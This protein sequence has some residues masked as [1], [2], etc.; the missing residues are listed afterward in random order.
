MKT[1]IVTLLILILLSSCSVV[2]KNGYY[3]SRTYKPRKALSIS[4]KKRPKNQTSHSPADLLPSDSEDDICA[5][6]STVSVIPEHQSNV[7]VSNSFVSDKV[8]NQD[9][10]GVST[11]KAKSTRLGR[12]FTTNESPRKAYLKRQNV[13]GE[14]ST[15]RKVVEWTAVILAVVLIIASIASF[16]ELLILAIG[17]IAI[18][19]PIA[20]FSRKKSKPKVLARYGMLSLVYLWTSFLIALNATIAISTLFI[21][22][23]GIFIYLAIALF[24]AAIVAAKKKSDQKSES[25]KEE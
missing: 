20:I 23:A 11:Q 12:T 14:V 5:A 8:T 9:I 7:K 19:L 1:S 16:Q 17:P 3:Q 22:A 25:K 4:F 18:F 15:A 13:T 21:Y 24:I 2:K 6:L 10:K